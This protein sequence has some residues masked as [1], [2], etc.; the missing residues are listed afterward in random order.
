MLNRFKHTWK[1]SKSILPASGVL[2]GLQSVVQ[3]IEMILRNFS[4]RCLSLR[5]HKQTA[6]W[7]CL[8][9]GRRGVTTS[10]S[11]RLV[12][13]SFTPL[14][15]DVPGHPLT[16]RTT[17]RTIGPLTAVAQKCLCKNNILINFVCSSAVA[18]MN[19]YIKRLGSF[20]SCQIKQR[21]KT[22]GI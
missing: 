5:W 22:F 7:V 6:C 2:T 10:P 21:I 18:G 8:C 3:K 14:F 13:D 4:K 12:L 19:M 9:E 15:T 17:L 11:W 20:S 16:V 1:K